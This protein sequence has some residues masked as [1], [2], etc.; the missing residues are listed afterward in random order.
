M[1]AAG[2]A[3][4]EKAEF[5]WIMAALDRDLADEV[6]HLRRHDLIDARGGFERIEAERF[7]DALLDRRARLLAIECVAAA[8]E[9]LRVDDAEND[10]RV[11]NGW[12]RAA[13]AVTRGPRLGARALRPD[14][15]AITVGPGDR[16]ATR[17]DS[18]HLDRG[19]MHGQPLIKEGRAFL[20][21]H[22]VYDQSDVEAGA[23]HVGG[24]DL[25]VTEQL[26]D[27]ARRH[28]SPDRPGIHDRNRLMRNCLRQ[29]HA[30][31]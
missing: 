15:Q 26:A 30:A 3:I 1:R 6:T 25:A 29:H 31:G 20:L 18:D 5:A 7:G 13:A 2:A 22:A 11:S 24:D 12:F 28:Q 8:E 17:A 27:V 9:I 19:H 10:E 4:G 23:A 16:A 14:L 21:E